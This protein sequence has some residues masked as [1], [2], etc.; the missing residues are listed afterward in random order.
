MSLLQLYMF[1][2]LLQIFLI[3][4]LFLL[5]L[6][7]LKNFLQ[8]L[9]KFLA[10]V[11]FFFELLQLFHVLYVPL[12]IKILLNVKMVLFLFPILKHYT[13][14]YIQM[15]NQPMILAILNTLLLLLFQMLALYIVFHLIFLHLL[16]LPKQLLVQILQ[17]D[18]FLFVINFLVL[19]QENMYFVLLFL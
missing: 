15:V 4:F 12:A 14:D 10:F 6:V 17:H 18:L 1:H 9:H 8:H 13:I 7:M 3:L 19:I 5:S 2:Q 16:L 11:K